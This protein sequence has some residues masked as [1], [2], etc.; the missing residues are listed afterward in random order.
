MVDFVDDADGA[1]GGVDFEEQAGNFGIEARGAD[2]AEEL[3]DGV[4]AREEAAFGIGSHDDAGEGDADDLD[5]VRRKGAVGE[6]FIE[7][8]KFVFARHPDA[9]GVPAGVPADDIHGGA[10]QQEAEAQ[11]GAGDGQQDGQGGAAASGGTGSR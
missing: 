7:V 3:F 11:Q 4:G 1:A 6:D 8:G 10:V 5:G 9:E 2:L